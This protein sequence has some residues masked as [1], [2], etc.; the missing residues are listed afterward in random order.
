MVFIDCFNWRWK[1]DII[2]TTVS[3]APEHDKCTV[4]DAVRFLMWNIHLYTTAL[5]LCDV[6]SFQPEDVTQSSLYPTTIAPYQECHFSP[7]SR[8]T[9]H[10]KMCALLWWVEG[11][12]PGSTTAIQSTKITSPPLTPAEDT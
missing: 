6:S 12:I 3:A 8:E 4:R 10:I 11:L 9:T 5:L 7:P 2:F 1:M